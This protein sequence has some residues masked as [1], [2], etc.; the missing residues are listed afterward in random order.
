[1]FKIQLVDYQNEKV[2]SSLQ[3]AECLNLEIRS[4]D[5]LITK[6]TDKLN[7]YGEVRFE[8]T[9]Q[10]KKIYYLNEN[11]SL[12]LGTLSKNT[13][14]V[15]EFKLALVGA[16]S[17][18][19]E[20]KALPDYPTALRQLATQYEVNQILEKQLKEAEE[21]RLTLLDREIN[22]DKVKHLKG[23]I[24]AFKDDEGRSINSYVI[25]HFFE[26]KRVD[27]SQAH[28]NAKEAY[29]KAT[30]EHL[31]HYAGNMSLDQKKSYRKFLSSL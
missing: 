26:G 19:R 2:V 28:T 17:K 18:L 10:N 29:Y 4:I 20:V 25:Q 14:L 11:Q 23:T 7:K 27:H 21:E 8:I 5:R 1:M 9:P 22:V 13:D 15:V 24:K 3:I 12:F 30:G 6:Y 31:P 16:Y